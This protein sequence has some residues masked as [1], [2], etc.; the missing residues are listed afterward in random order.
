M[1]HMNIWWYSTFIYLFIFETHWICGKWRYYRIQ[2][3]DY[4][5]LN[6]NMENY[7]SNPKAVMVF[8]CRN[9]ENKDERRNKNVGQLFKSVHHWKRFLPLQQLKIFHSCSPTLGR[10]GLPHLCPEYLPSH[11]E[12][13][14]IIQDGSFRITMCIGTL[15]AFLVLQD[16]TKRCHGA[17]VLLA[18][19]HLL[20]QLKQ[21]HEEVKKEGRGTVLW[22]W[23]KYYTDCCTLLNSFYS[24]YYA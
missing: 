16:I 11:L 24:T 8:N 22:R 17:S 23:Y 3:I 9:T 18:P 2:D 1:T 4:I 5:N 12:E 13:R 15:N 14:E 20:V 19:W 7:F 6:T 21:V 10:Q